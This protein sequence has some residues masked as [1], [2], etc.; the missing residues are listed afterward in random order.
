MRDQDGA[1]AAGTNADHLARLVDLDRDRT[2]YDPTV[3]GQ[4]FLLSARRRP[5]TGAFGVRS[6]AIGVPYGAC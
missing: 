1:G 3:S 4:M 2:A 6:G 5:P